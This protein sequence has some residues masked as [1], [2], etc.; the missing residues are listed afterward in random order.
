LLFGFALAGLHAGH[1]LSLQLPVAWEKREVTVV[2]RIVDLPEHHSRRTSF[3]FRVEDERAQP[4][5]LRGRLLR[6][7]WY[8]DFD[9][10]GTGRERLRAGQRWQLTAR[11]RAP[12]GLRNPGGF[13]SEK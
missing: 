11:V 6:V 7:S 8:D 12:R 10:S 9:G 4:E 2:G 13:D 5:A 1:A 3:G